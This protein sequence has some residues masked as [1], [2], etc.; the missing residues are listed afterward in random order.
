[1]SSDIEKRMKGARC[2]LSKK[3]REPSVP[4]FMRQLLTGCFQPEAKKT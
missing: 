1:M 2:I 4:E 3:G